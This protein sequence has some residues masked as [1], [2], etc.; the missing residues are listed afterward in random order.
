MIS[1]TKNYY[2]IVNENSIWHGARNNLPETNPRSTAV[3]NKNQMSL[4][5]HKLL[6]SLKALALGKYFLKLGEGKI[7]HTLN[8]F[9]FFCLLFKHLPTALQQLHDSLLSISSWRNPAF[10]TVEGSFIHFYFVFMLSTNMSGVKGNL[11]KDS[12]RR[13]IPSML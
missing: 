13:E 1:L 11:M 2:F 3:K 10:C 5:L 4:W 7:L 8:L 12:E 9:F 6:S